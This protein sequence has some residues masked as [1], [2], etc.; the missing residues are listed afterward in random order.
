M[1]RG[2][3]Q[4]SVRTSNTKKKNKTTENKLHGIY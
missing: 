3:K 1:K 2:K 4:H